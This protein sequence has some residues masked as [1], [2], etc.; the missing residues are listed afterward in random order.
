MIKHRNTRQLVI[1]LVALSGLFV[2]SLPTAFSQETTNT[3]DTATNTNADTNGTSTGMVDQPQADPI[4]DLNAQIQGK[5]KH[6]QEL[7]EQAAGYQQ[8]ADAASS[9]IHDMQSQISGI[10]AQITATSFDIQAKEEEIASLEL[11]I[12]SLQQSIDDKNDLI[13]GRRDELASAIRQLDVNARTT[14][15][16]LV[17]TKAS[18]ADFYSQ[19]QATASI[20]SSLSDT[21]ET[22]K[23]LRAEL[24]TRQDEL[25]KAKDDVRQAKLQLEVNKQA[26]VD[27]KSLKEQL[28]TTSQRSASQYTELL[29]RSALEEQQASATIS[30]LERQIQ[31]RL[32]G[33]SDQ[34]EFSSV[35][36][37]WP[38]QSRSISAYFLDPTYPYRCT[39]WKNSYCREHYGLDIRT[40]QGTPVRA[41]ADGIISVVYDQGFYYDTAGQKTGSALNFVGLVHDKGVS[42][43]YLHLSVIYVHIDQFVRQGD[44]IGLSGGMP[45]TAGAGGPGLSSG[46]HLHLE[47]RENGLPIDPLKYLP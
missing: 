30:A 29:Q 9:Q 23:R 10:D 6:I 31:D 8:Q 24:Q 44:I 39:L 33:G 1:G 26:T 14:T 20:S 42:T 18:L 43:R 46:P 17:I 47:V 12:R 41:T 5:Q 11:E 16:T 19:A 37:I 25:T 15:L 21:I 2:F 3:N 45:G 4:A 40:P 34:P 27:Q 28:L 35:G 36:F 13:N 38:V 22:M 32:N 7:R